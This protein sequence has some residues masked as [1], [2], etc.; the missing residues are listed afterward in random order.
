MEQDWKPIFTQNISEVVNNGGFKRGELTKL[1]IEYANKYNTDKDIFRNFYYRI[2]KK[3]KES[4]LDTPK[5]SPKNESEKKTKQTDSKGTTNSKKI[6]DSKS[7]EESKK[8]LS[9]NK[10]D[11]KSFKDYPGDFTN[12]FTYKSKHSD[13]E[14]FDFNQ[15]DKNIVGKDF[16]EYVKSIENGKLISRCFI[17]N[18][19][20]EIEVI[21]REKLIKVLTQFAGYTRHHNASRQAEILVNLFRAD[22]SMLEER[23]LENYYESLKVNDVFKF[24]VK[25][26]MPYGVLVELNEN[27]KISGIIHISEIK[28]GFVKEEELHQLF[29][30]GELIDAKILLKKE[31][32]KLNLSLKGLDVPI[33]QKIKEFDLNHK[34]NSQ[35]ASTLEESKEIVPEIKSELEIEAKMPDEWKE[36]LDFVKSFVGPLSPEAKDKLNELIKEFGIFKFSRGIN[37]ATEN[38]KSDFGLILLSKAETKLRDGL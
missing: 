28:N 12:I 24:C 5:E 1:C 34:T 6:T 25:K 14:W 33:T 27:E 32:L 9:V 18:K 26:I 23:R 36:I 7:T 20:K 38:F 13:V 16:K 11:L 8:I 19:T 21:E 4:S 10:E 29:T 35:V 2:I 37:A 17:N 22:D 31:A 15:V 30:E 3:M